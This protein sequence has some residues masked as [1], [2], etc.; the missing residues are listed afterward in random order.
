MWKKVCIDID[1]TILDINS[2]LYKYGIKD[3]ERVY[4]HPLLDEN[5]FVSPEGIRLIMSAEPIQ[6]T[7]KIIKK[8]SFNGTE[9]IFATSRPVQLKDIT[10]WQLKKLGLKGKLVFTKDKRVVEADVYIEDDPLQILRLIRAGKRVLSPAWDY[11]AGYRHPNYL[12][13]RRN[14]R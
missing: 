13:Y 7:M 3:V 11:N 6:G 5:F 1:N 9:M 8:L 10:I 14:P 2:Q 4:P 12:R